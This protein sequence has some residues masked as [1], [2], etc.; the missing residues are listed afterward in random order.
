MIAGEK[1]PVF[2]VKKSAA[3]V[4]FFLASAP[5]LGHRAFPTFTLAEAEPEIYCGEVSMASVSEYLAFV[6][7]QDD[8]Y[9]SYDRFHLDLLNE[10][11]VQIPH[12]RR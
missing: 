5:F 11:H 8:N 6:D 12:Y 4:H 3:A 9:V 2:S 7:N 10:R 1:R